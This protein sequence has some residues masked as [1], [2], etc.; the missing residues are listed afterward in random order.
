VRLEEL[1]TPSADQIKAAAATISEAANNVCFSPVI[2]AKPFTAKKSKLLQSSLRKRVRKTFSNEDDDMIDEAPRKRPCEPPYGQL[3]SM[4]PVR[5][6]LNFDQAVFET[7]I[8]GRQDAFIQMIEA[9]AAVPTFVN[10][11]EANEKNKI[12]SSTAS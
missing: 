8:V 4:D 2:T 1:T 12:N 7:P 10:S 3:N 5:R 9:S 6:R 11:S